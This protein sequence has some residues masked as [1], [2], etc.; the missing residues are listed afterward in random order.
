MKII[1]YLPFMLLIAAVGFWSPSCGGGGGTT[2]EPPID[3]GGGGGGGVTIDTN[4]LTFAPLLGT[5]G[6]QASAN[7]TFGALGY[8]PSLTNVSAAL[9][10]V[11]KAALEL[12]ADIIAQ[13]TPTIAYDQPGV[14]CDYTCDNVKGA[15]QQL[16]MEGSCT[17]TNY[18]VGSAIG[19]FVVNG[20]APFRFTIGPALP[21]GVFSFALWI[22]LRAGTPL[23]ITIEGHTIDLN[24]LTFFEQGTASS[25]SLDGVS[26]LFSL[27]PFTFS[28]TLDGADFLCLVDSL[29][30]E[31]FCMEFCGDGVDNSGDGLI[32]C[33]DVQCAESSDCIGHEICDNVIDDNGNGKA[34]CDDVECLTFCYPAPE[35]C[36][37]GIDNDGDGNIDCGDGECFYFMMSPN[38]PC[39][40]V[41]G[42]YLCTDLPEFDCT[43]AL[44]GNVGPQCDANGDIAGLSNPALSCEEFGYH[45]YGWYSGGV[46]TCAAYGG[47]RCCV[48]PLETQ[49]ND[50]ADNDLDGTIDCADPDCWDVIPSYCG[51]VC[52]NACDV[53]PP[54][55]YDSFLNCADTE[56]V[57]HSACQVLTETVCTGGGDEDNDCWVDCGDK[58]CCTADPVN[59]GAHPNCSKP[60]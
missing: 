24:V 5:A 3:D 58:D 45:Q 13:C 41:G 40:D 37:D 9:S 30:R 50:G 14:H 17:Y 11:T 55:D 51:E 48:L 60:K 39:N 4:P 53:D 18:V 2:T 38:A 25:F 34:D 16:L 35:L 7:S 31:L 10:P 44:C 26:A 57:G 12:P 21:S 43:D 36:D 54:D 1:K 56:C 15:H 47:A 27:T 46:P 28:Y 33:A 6:A 52:N 59:C 20:T 23:Q 19:D 22:N 29:T 8:T 42:V 32:D 49:C